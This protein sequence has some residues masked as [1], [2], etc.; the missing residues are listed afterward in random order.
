MPARDESV[1]AF[2]VVTEPAHGPVRPAGRRVHKTACTRRGQREKCTFAAVNTMPRYSA[3][4]LIKSIRNAANP[5]GIWLSLSVKCVCVAVCIYFGRI[6][7]AY[8]YS[9]SDCRTGV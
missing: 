3:T 9:D 7:Q 2:P 6:F 8:L 5:S 1:A 4:S